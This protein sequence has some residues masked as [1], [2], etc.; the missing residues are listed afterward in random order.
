MDRIIFVAIALLL[1][2][3]LVVAGLMLARFLSKREVISHKT[4]IASSILAGIIV[5]IVGILMSI[6]TLAGSGS[7]LLFFVLGIILLAIFVRTTHCARTFF[8]IECIIITCFPNI[9]SCNTYSMGR[10]HFDDY[11]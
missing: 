6:A 3:L 9:H 8:K 11:S 1:G 10:F 4:S 5:F 2:P 7:I